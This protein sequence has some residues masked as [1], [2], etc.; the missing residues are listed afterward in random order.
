M[1]PWIL[2]EK[3]NTV[4]PHK[5]SIKALWETKWKFACEKSVYPFHDGAIEDF[6]PIF[7]KLIDENINDAYTDAYTQAFFPVAEALENKASAALNNNNVEMA[8][9]LL[10]RAAVVYRISRFPYVDPTREDIKKEAFN[11]Q[12]KVYLKAASF[13]KPTIQEVIIPHKHKSATDGAYVPLFVRVPEHATAEN[14]VPVVVLMT[15]LDGYRP[16]NSQR[17]HEIINR[18]WATVICEIPGTADSPADPSD[19]ESADRQWTTVL[20]YMA[21]RPEFDMSRVAAWGLSAGGFYA[22]RAAHTHRDRFVGTLAHGPG[23]HYF[24]DPEWLSRVDDHEYPFLLTPAWAKKYGYS[25]PEDFKK[26]GQKKFSLL[27]TGILDQPSCRL[28]LL[29]GVDDGVTPIEDC[30]MLFNHG[31]PKEG[32]FFH[33][34]PH[35][36]YPHSLVPSYKW[37]EDVLRSPQ[38]PLKN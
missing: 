22:I 32:R 28:L 7:Q 5:G 31:S 38:E 12:K 29:N 6:R 20:D 37:F 30:L 16:D 10:R 8:S 27:E 9:D 21:T 11:R 19:P 2:G 33:G 26:H 1:A 23:C 34:L 18:G 3:F 4:Y 35:M 24:L 15:G 25:N 36:G 17:T 14:P 13:W